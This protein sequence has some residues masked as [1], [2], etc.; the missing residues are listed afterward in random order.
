ME[1]FFL[2]F[3]NKSYFA[4]QKLTHTPASRQPGASYTQ[5][6]PWHAKK[7]FRFYSRSSDD[8]TLLDHLWPTDYTDVS[9]KT[10]SDSDV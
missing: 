7:G 1:L 6:S 2:R 3:R 10:A 9:M 4:P 5:R 8:E